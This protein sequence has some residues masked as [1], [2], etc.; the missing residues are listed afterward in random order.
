MIFSNVTHTAELVDGSSVTINGGGSIAITASSLGETTV[1][2][3]GPSEPVAGKSAGIG[4]SVALGIVED[5]V[6]ATSAG[7]RC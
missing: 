5:T 2:N 7:V 3:Q 1:G 4:A 6:T